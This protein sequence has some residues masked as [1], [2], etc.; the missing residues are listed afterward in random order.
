[1]RI[2]NN[3][4]KSTTNRHLEYASWA[5]MGISLALMICSAFVSATAMG[6]ALT[7]YDNY[8]FLKERSREVFMHSSI[9]MLF[10]MMGLFI[11][12]K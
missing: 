6:E 5:G 7:D 12:N 4:V 1:M 8:L 9:M 2:M 11:S 10:S 3:Y